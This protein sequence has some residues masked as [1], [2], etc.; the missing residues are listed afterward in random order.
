MKKVI[1]LLWE[2]E[3]I[4]FAPSYFKD[5]DCEYL[6]V[7]VGNKRDRIFGKKKWDNVKEENWYQRGRNHFRCY[8]RTSLGGFVLHNDNFLDTSQFKDVMKAAVI[9]ENDTLKVWFSGLIHKNW[10]IYFCQK[11]KFGWGKIKEVEILDMQHE[12]VHMYLPCVMKNNIYRMWFVCRDCH[13]RRIFHVVSKDGIVWNNSKLVM[14][15]GEDGEGDRYAVDCPDVVKIDNKYIMLYGGGTSRGIHLAIS[16]DGFTW[17]K[18]GLVISR[19]KSNESNYYYSFYPSIFSVNTSD[20]G[21]ET[22]EVFFAGEDINNNWCILYAKDIGYNPDIIIK[23]H[24]VQ[25]I[26][27]LILNIPGSYLTDQDDCNSKGNYYES[28]DIKQLRPS[29]RPVFL[30]KK[31]NIVAKIMKN[32]IRAENEYMARIS[33]FGVINIVSVQINYFQ[34]NV[35][36][37]MPYIENSIGLN[38]L[39][40]FKPAIFSKVTQVFLADYL[41]IIKQNCTNYSNSIADQTEQTLNLLINWCKELEKL[42]VLSIFSLVNEKKYDLQKEYI[43]TIKFISLPPSK[44]S[45]FN[46]DTN[47]RNVLFKDMKLYYIDFEFLGYFDVDYLMAKLIGSLFKHCEIF[48]FEECYKERGIVYIDYHFFE[49]VREV[50]D[51]LKDALLKDDIFNCKRI[52]AFIM[53]KFYFRLKKSF[54]DINAISA[55]IQLTRFIARLDFF[56]RVIYD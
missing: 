27:S 10:K 9:V 52:R 49:D 15:I 43:N 55:K 3:M 50:I 32:R 6:V 38:E 40:S 22:L 19:G 7:T 21:R 53:A 5:R 47:F 8:K 14:D 35:L 37:L 46:G 25:E 12:F 51:T 54:G 33:F 13:H 28:S 41:K 42:C 4:M 1:K 39:S 31:K 24:E 30:L 56:E 45:Y 20:Y 26:Y 2:K 36:I 16:K 29:T 11:N 48:D 18:K 34:D 44:C 17:D 23:I